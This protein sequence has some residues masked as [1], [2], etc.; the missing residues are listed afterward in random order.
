A[1]ASGE[2]DV[3]HLSELEA[4]YEEKLNALAT[5]LYGADGVEF[6]PEAK[7]EAARLES[8]GFGNLPVCVAKTQYSLS[9]DA[10]LKGRPTGFSFPVR[11]LRLAAG[12]GFVIAYAGNIMTM[13]G[14][15][16]TPGYK[17]VDLDS[18]GR[19][20]GLF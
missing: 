16:R 17:N 7:A 13:P 4:G 18:E 9:H 3:R 6:S 15:G 19:I 10:K 5:N 12:A 2:A 20:V 8:S 14:L 11:D 1:A